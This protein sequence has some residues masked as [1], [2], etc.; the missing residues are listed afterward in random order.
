MQVENLSLAI[1]KQNKFSIR[2]FIHSGPHRQI[3]SLLLQPLEKSLVV[4]ARS[5]ADLTMFYG[6]HREGKSR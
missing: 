5:E 3:W 6:F 1:K 2:N 4:L